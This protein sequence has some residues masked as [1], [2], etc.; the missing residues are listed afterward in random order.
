MEKGTTP[1]FTALGSPL[2]VAEAD[3]VSTRLEAALC[4]L[5]SFLS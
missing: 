1:I 5:V 3:R 4:R 2:A